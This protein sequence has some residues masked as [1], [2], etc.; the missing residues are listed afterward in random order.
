MPHLSLRTRH[1]LP[2]ERRGWSLGAWRS[3]GF[4]QDRLAQCSQRGAVAGAELVRDSLHE[5]V[6]FP[7]PVLAGGVALGA[8][9]G[10]EPE[11]VGA[12]ALGLREFSELELQPQ[13]KPKPLEVMPVKVM[14]PSRW[15][16]I[17]CLGMV[18]KSL[19]L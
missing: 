13:R 3:G 10:V 4:G 14:L 7:N 6:E 19:S 12:G 11:I 17:S 5:A 8:G 18:A 16:M 15:R 2:A 1:A 9:G